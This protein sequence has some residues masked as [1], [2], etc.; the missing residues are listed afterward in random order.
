M[1]FTSLLGT[2][3]VDMLT[4]LMY[5]LPTFNLDTAEQMLVKGYCRDVPADETSGQANCFVHN[6]ASEKTTNKMRGRSFNAVTPGFLA[7]KDDNDDKTTPS[8][9]ESSD[10]RVGK[11]SSMTSNKILETTIADLYASPYMTSKIQ[12]PPKDIDDSTEEEPMDAQEIARSALYN[13]GITSDE[14]ER[15]FEEHADEARPKDLLSNLPPELLTTTL[16]NLPVKEILGAKCVSRHFR[17]LIV[18]SDALLFKKQAERSMERVNEQARAILVSEGDKPH[19]VR[20]LAIFLSNRGIQ[21]NVMSRGR[22]ILTFCRQWQ[23]VHEPMPENLTEDMRSAREFDLRIMKTVAEDIVDYHVHCHA[24]AA[25]KDDYEYTQDVD[26][27]GPPR[28]DLKGYVADFKAFLLDHTTLEKITKFLPSGLIECYTSVAT[29]SDGMLE[30][31]IFVSQEGLYNPQTGRLPGLYRDSWTRCDHVPSWP[32]TKIEPRFEAINRKNRKNRS[33]R[34]IR[35]DGMCSVQ[36]LS[37]TLGFE[38]PTLPTSN[39]DFAYC[40]ESQEAYDAAVFGCTKSRK[41]GRLSWRLK[42]LLLQN[43]YLY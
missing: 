19:F 17:D 4:D 12:P 1:T 21:A 31:Y 8:I 32:L 24:E 28:D 10:I 23:A 33:A 38:L 5:L 40:V 41:G 13:A 9:N 14:S 39:H 18:E 16:A 34:S 15:E 36:R 11:P 37:A 2:L 7:G 29:P 22:D 30:V 20:S 27:P 3:L 6:I 43:L 25:S 42:A 26:A 35:R